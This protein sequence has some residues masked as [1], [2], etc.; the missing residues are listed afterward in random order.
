MGKL[1]V[2]IV[3][4][5]LRPGRDLRASLVARESFYFS[6]VKIYLDVY[7]RTRTNEGFEDRELRQALDRAGNQ[8]AL[9]GRI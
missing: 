8:K 6:A 9:E 2:D 1:M 5:V 4:I 7:N 3:K